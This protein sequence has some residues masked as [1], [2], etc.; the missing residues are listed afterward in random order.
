MDD[1]Y[2][3]GMGGA[4]C[5]GDGRNSDEPKKNYGAGETL[6]DTKYMLSLTFN[7]PEV[8]FNDESECLFKGKIVDDLFLPLHMNFR[9][10]GMSPRPTIA[11]YDVMKN[12]DA[13]G[14]FN[15]FAEY[16]EANF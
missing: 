3:A 2:T 6:S 9:F 14:D 1:V 15:R 10:F 13:K 5:H 8:S 12:V 7:T 4:L 16:I 11:C